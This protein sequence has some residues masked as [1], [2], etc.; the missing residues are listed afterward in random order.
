MCRCN[1][2]ISTAVQRATANIPAAVE[3]HVCLLQ[4][5]L[6]L[7]LQR[8]LQ[9][10][11]EASVL[12]EYCVPA[13]QKVMTEK[14]FAMTPDGLVPII[15]H[16]MYN[17]DLANLVQQINEGTAAAA[18]ANPFNSDDYAAG[19]AVD[20]LGDLDDEGEDGSPYME[21][22]IVLAQGILKGVVDDGSAVK[23]FEVRKHS[24][25]RCKGAQ[26]HPRC[27]QVLCGVCMLCLLVA[28]HNL[29]TTETHVSYCIRHLVCALQHDNETSMITRLNKRALL[30]AC[31]VE[32]R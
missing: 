30:I 4:S 16:L 1:V 22:I 27:C 6:S 13:D 20:I 25:T 23:V 26:P 31:P 12:E 11:Y 32:C 18:A 8:A 17:K 9:Q 5:L 2:Q 29:C 7:L 19:A 21:P 14:V 10:L 3:T 15:K 28:C 24:H